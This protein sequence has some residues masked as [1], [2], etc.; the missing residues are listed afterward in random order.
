VLEPNNVT[1]LDTLGYILSK[2]PE[3]LDE[4]E[5]VLRRALRI[6]PK[7][8]SALAGVGV[9]LSARGGA[10]DLSE[11]LR[12]CQQAVAVA[13]SEGRIA[14]ADALGAHGIVLLRSGDA[15]A[16]RT[17]LAEAQVLDACNTYV[18]ELSLLLEQR[19]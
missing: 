6:E 17:R 10:G 13:A 4:A 3:R 19:S 15:V 16:A 9:F 1:R 11:A 8:F 18:T 12:L 14:R 5:Q 2:D 7:S